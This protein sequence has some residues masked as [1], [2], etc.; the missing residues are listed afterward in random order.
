MFFQRIHQSKAI[1]YC[2]YIKIKKWRTVFIILFFKNGERVR[3]KISASIGGD[4][5]LKNNTKCHNG[6]R[7]HWS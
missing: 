3:S 4:G 1:L 7:E 6:G 2:E 5:G